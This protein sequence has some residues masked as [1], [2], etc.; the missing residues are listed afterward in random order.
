TALKEQVRFAKGG[1]ETANFDDY[2]LLRMSEVP[3]IEVHIVKSTEKI[4]GIGEP[5]VPPVA[6]AIANAIFNATGARV[7]RLP[8]TPETVL[9][10]I[11]NKA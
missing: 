5:G 4:G 1:V 11:R 8:M 3:E 9:A 10:A 7:R 6:P 2:H